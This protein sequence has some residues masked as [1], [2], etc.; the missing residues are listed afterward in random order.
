M[1]RPLTCAV[2]STAP[3]A[4]LRL[5]GFLD[6]ESA[7]DL[8]TV[9]HKALAGQPTAIVVDL[10]ELRVDEDVVLTVF[11]AFA[12]TAAGW[13]GCPVLLCAPEAGLATALDRIA[14]SRA[15]PVYRDREQALAAADRLP[16]P[17]RFDQLLPATP[18][19]C[20]VARQLVD[21][22]CRTWQ[23]TD[24]VEDAELVVTELVTNAVRHAGRD[25]SLSVV[26]RDHFLH[27]AVRD[28][29][30][31]P[32][33]RVLPDPDSGEGGRGLLL[34]EAVATGW[35]STSTTSG[36]SVWATLRLRR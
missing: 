5:A 16:A 21:T 4:V 25:I 32:P 18:A 29:S 12:R 22:A 19:A 36:K 24:L 17:R 11:T 10:G 13:S 6:L 35:G 14:V 27:L 33:R 7:A 34:V 31:A 30:H 23:L 1:T 2:E 3:V 15:V 20:V 8:R 9:L 28:G 26:L